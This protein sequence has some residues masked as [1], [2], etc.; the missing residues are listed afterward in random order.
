MKLG[1]T[2]GNS[3]LSTPSTLSRGGMPHQ[4]CSYPVAD[5][6]TFASTLLQILLIL[7]PRF[8]ELLLTYRKVSQPKINRVNHSSAV[9]CPLDESFI[10]YFSRAV[11]CDGDAVANPGL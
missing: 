9:H 6:T 11:G 4:R 2:S 3:Q 1:N 7:L 10:R 8:L 5:K